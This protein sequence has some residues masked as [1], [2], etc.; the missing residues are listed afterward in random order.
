MI[1]KTQALLM[2]LSMC[3]AATASDLAPVLLYHGGGGAPV[4]RPNGRVHEAS[5]A[6][7]LKLAVEDLPREIQ[8]RRGQFARES[9]TDQGGTFESPFSRV[10]LDELTVS[11]RAVEFIGLDTAKKQFRDYLLERESGLAAIAVDF[12]M[13]FRGGYV[14]ARTA[15]AFLEAGKGPTDG[16]R[17]SVGYISGS[18]A[19]ADA[20][21]DPLFDDS[22][23][24][25]ARDR[26]KNA[27]AR[28][29]WF[30]GSPTRAAAEL[31]NHAQDIARIVD[32]MIRSAGGDDNIPDLDTWY[33]AL[34]TGKDLFESKGEKCRK[35]C[36]RK[37]VD[38]GSGRYA[39]VL[40]E[41]IWLW[42]YSINQVPN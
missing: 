10:G 35:Q 22:S 9:G 26:E 31:A 24:V 8:D 18:R 21:Q 16:G 5:D 38:L 14:E 34:P 39:V 41:G 33:A 11:R 13:Y 25:S 29:Y 3:A 1:L 36:R 23:E 27:P 6:W 28:E 4:Q 30:G 37:Y 15:V 2:F 42:D 12:S 17:F 32:Q 40:K 7:L 19:P 20:R